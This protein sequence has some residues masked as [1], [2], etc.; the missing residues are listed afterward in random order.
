MQTAKYNNYNLL[1]IMLNGYLVTKKVDAYNRTQR[2]DSLEKMWLTNYKKKDQPLLIENYK[3]RI[4]RFV[5][6]VS[7]LPDGW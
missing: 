4:D 5:N 2:K 1:Y 3:S 6:D 7:A